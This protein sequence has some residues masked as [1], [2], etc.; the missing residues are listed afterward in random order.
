VAVE[1]GF[2]GLDQQVT[3]GQDAEAGGPFE[4][5]MEDLGGGPG[6]VESTV[7]RLGA[8]TE[9]SGQ[10]GQPVIS[11]LAGQERPGQ[12]Q[13]VDPGVT[14]LRTARGGQVGVEEERVEAEVVADEHRVAHELEQGG[15]D[16]L[17][18][19]GEPEKRL[20]DPGQPHDE[21]RDGTLR[22]DQR[23]ERPEAFPTPVLRGSD[24]DDAVL[25]RCGA[26]RLQVDHDEGDLG[27]GS[28]EAGLGRRTGRRH[29]AG[30]GEWGRKRPHAWTITTG[31]DI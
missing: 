23:L 5:A 11:H 9:K 6:V 28:A 26:R 3:Q 17:D 25:A 27:E 2:P 8:G 7:G 19:R 31:C 16:L 24:F 18:G 22:V 12:G 30:S 10:G 15:Q 1:R 4:Q 29:P 13:C 20:A 21:R 14:Q